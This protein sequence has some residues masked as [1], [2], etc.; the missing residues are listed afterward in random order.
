MAVSQLDAVLKVARAICFDSRNLQAGCAFVAIRGTKVDGHQFLAQAV[1]A[2]AAALVVE[3]TSL[4]PSGF[5]GP[6][7]VV[8][9]A[10]DAL[11]I[12]RQ[13]FIVNLHASSLLSV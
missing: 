5:A 6:V 3:D 10:R 11:N 1:Q 4:I 7:A 2:G 8:A 9:N 13:N 12:W